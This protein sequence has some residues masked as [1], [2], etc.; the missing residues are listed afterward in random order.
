[1]YS[2][3]GPDLGALGPEV[4]CG[5]AQLRFFFSGPGRAGTPGL[6]RYECR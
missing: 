2:C 3:S 6:H 4:G 1:M 5:Y